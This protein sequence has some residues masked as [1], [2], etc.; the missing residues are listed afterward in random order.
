MPQKKTGQDLVEIT[1]TV[2]NHE[3][4]GETVK[5]GD[6]IKVSQ[7]VAEMLQSQWDAQQKN[8]KEA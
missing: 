5:K 7:P 6:K 8:N 3:H 1:V 4:A 2:D